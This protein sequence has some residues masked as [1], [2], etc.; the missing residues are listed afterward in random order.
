MKKSKNLWI[1]ILIGATL[2][3]I[4]VGLINL[5]LITFNHYL[6]EG[7]FAASLLL[8]VGLNILI[9]RI[10]FKKS[11]SFIPNGIMISSM[12][13]FIYWAIRFLLSEN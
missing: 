7:I 8:G 2:P 13:I 12:F 9:I 5:G 6:T 3:F 4:L 10:W 11:N 1:G